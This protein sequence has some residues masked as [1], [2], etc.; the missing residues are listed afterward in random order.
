MPRIKDPEVE[1]LA[2]Y[3]RTLQTDYQSADDAAW[4]DSPFAWI[5]TRPSR[6]AGTIG[7]KLTSGYLATKGFDVV[8]SPDTEADRIIAGQRAEIK[9]STLWKGGSYRFQQ[10][11][12]QN[13]EFAVCLGLSPFD[14][15]CWVLPKNLIL[16]QWSAGVISSQHG[17]RSGSDT[18]WLHVS[19]DAIPEWLTEWGGLLS[20]A[21]EVITRITGQ[22]PLK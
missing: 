14:A 8:R 11:R 17:G 2:S 6:Q 13:Y 16:R 21:V 1:I 7:E 15:H 20:D 3:S 22:A 9:M 5:K 10:L 19:P 4:N 18:A 12:D